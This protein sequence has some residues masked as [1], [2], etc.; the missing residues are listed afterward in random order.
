[1]TRA[2]EEELATAMRNRVAGLSPAPD[3]V[4]RAVRA[5]RR[6]ARIRL[7]ASVT[8]AAGITAMAVGVVISLPGTSIQPSSPGSAAG[9]DAASSSRPTS[10][11]A[12]ASPLPTS[13][14]A[15]LLAAMTS[16]AQVSYRMHVVNL[17]VDP[18]HRVTRTSPPRDL[19]QPYADYTGVYDPKTRSGYG[20]N[21]E[22]YDTGGLG[23]P[24][25]FGKP[26][27]YEQV[28]I[29]G[30][31]YYTRYSVTNSFRAGSTWTSG[32]GSLAIAL[33][34]NGGQGWAPTSGGSADPAVLLA[35]VRRLGQVRLAGHSGSGAQ[36]LDTYK[37]R[38]HLA[39]NSSVQAHQLT[40]TIVVH[41]QS[42]L[43]AS[44]TMQTTVTGAHP[45]IGDS[46]QTTF[47][48][49]LTFSDYGVAV[50]VRPPTAISNS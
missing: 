21:I 16:S 27:N 44:I 1:M 9:P 50:S 14:R 25:L 23:D 22:R 38:Y 15:R 43:I 18:G 33:D 5:H 39:G 48:T 42:N 12:H 26:G 41:H 10:G 32:S 29:I 19:I 24:R 40:G 8:A 6:S 46:G 4:A 30:N 31:T 49:V 34:L 13:P 20:L 36:A 47:R 28:R 45:K 7:G 2:I 3:I 17:S 11:A 37:F 35:T